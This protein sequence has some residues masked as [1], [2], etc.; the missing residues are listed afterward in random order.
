VTGNFPKERTPGKDEKPEDKTRLDKEFADNLKK[1]DERLKA[2]RK[3]SDWIYVVSKWTVDPLLKV[4]H[5][6]LEEKKEEKKD[7]TKDAAT[8]ATPL[9]LPP[10]AK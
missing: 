4:R 1:L 8:P 7:E 10:A 5:E 3:F 9:V 2:D 6:L